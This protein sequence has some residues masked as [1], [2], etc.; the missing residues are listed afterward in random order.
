LVDTLLIY[1]QQS[2]ESMDRFQEMSIFRAVVDAGSFTQAAE[3]LGL[4]KAAVSRSI[5][6]L[7]SRLCI[8]LLNRTTR[9]LSVTEEGQT[10]HARCTS[11]LAELDEAEA[12]ITVRSGQALGL[13]RVA[14][15]LS[16]G[17]A[18]LA[19]LWGDFLARHPQLRLE[20]SLNDRVVDLVEEGFD[21]AIRIG[22][23]TD[24][25]LISRRLASTPLMLCASPRY[26]RRH[27]TPRQ[28]QDLGQ[29][30]VLAYSLFA[31]GNLWTLT[32]AGETEQVRVVPRLTANNGDTCV[33][34]ALHHAGIVLQPHFLVQDALREGA[35]VPVLKDWSAGELGIHAVYPGR[36]HVG[37]KVRLLIDELAR[38]LPGRLQGKG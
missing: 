34:A 11:L 33:Q 30:D 16:F 1:S 29:H 37:P 27:G 24:S 2:F 38:R 20:V 14:A 28:P 12:E 23:L 8:R 21:V 32:K 26:L 31:S 3:R 9:R 35:L 22:R 10:F 36:A 25:S 13:L 5:T 18:H 6:Q 15:P 4:S 19:S 7:E 17:V